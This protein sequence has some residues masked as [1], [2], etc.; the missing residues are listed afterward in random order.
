[1][2]LIKLHDMNNPNREIPMD[3]ADFSVALPYLEGSAVRLKS[4]DS[5][6]LV[7]ETPEQIEAILGAV[8]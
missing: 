7:Y 4:S 6:F 8:E 2:Q 3:A 5:C 1:M